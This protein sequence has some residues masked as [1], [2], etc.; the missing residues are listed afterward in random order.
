M[1]SSLSSPCPQTEIISHFILCLRPELASLNRIYLVNF[2]CFFFRCFAFHSPLLYCFAELS[3]HRKGAERG[4]T[5]E[6]KAKF[7]FIEIPSPYL[8]FSG[9]SRLHFKE[10][11]KNVFA[12]VYRK[13]SRAK[14]KWEK[15]FFFRVYRRNEWEKVTSFGDSQLMAYIL[16]VLLFLPLLSLICIMHCLRAKVKHRERE[17]EIRIIHHRR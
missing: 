11:R 4:N 8:A 15:R 10:T 16:P 6:N 17:R 1:N 2:S 12:Q 5:E 9:S 7:S 3:K 14:E 13:L